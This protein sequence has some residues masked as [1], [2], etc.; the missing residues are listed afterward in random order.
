MYFT[1]LDPTFIASAIKTFIYFYC[2]YISHLIKKV[3]L[4]T[5]KTTYRYNAIGCFSLFLSF[6]IFMKQERIIAFDFIRAITII[7]VVIGHYTPENSPEWY[8]NLNKA[9]HT[10]RMPVFL[11]ISGFIYIISRKSDNYGSFIWKK[12]KRLLLPYYVTSIIV[13]TIKLLTQENA[14]M[15]NPVS[16]DT[17]FKMFYLPVAGYYLWFIMALLWM[18]IVT[19]LFNTKKQRLM[20]FFASI[21][22]A[23][24]PIQFTFIFCL[25]EFKDMFLYFMTGVVAGD[26]YGSIK[27]PS[28]TTNFS[29]IAIFLVS[30]WLFLSRICTW[31]EYILPFIGIAFAMIVANLIERSTLSSFKRELLTISSASFIIYLF[32]TTFLGFAKALMF[33]YNSVFNIY[34]NELFFTL[35]ILFA[36]SAGVICP[37]CLYFIFKRFNAT[38]YIFGM[39]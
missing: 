33:K 27:K 10:F 8:V 19:H 37:I 29:I 9:L 28:T 6:N 25:H 24:I 31:L 7:L 21:F 2:L 30:Q 16:F 18:F 35:G 11:F 15:Q 38:R 13:I 17:Y 12:A 20:L 23:Y 26:W 32:H 14:Y 36:I 3:Y 4:C 1:L 5:R 39:K 34:E 22:L